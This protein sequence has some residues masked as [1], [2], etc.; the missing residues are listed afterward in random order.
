MS[1]ILERRLA[2]REPRWM[3]M[4]CV[5]P[6]GAGPAST[7]RCSAASPAGAPAPCGR[8][9]QPAAGPRRAGGGRR[10][11]PRAA[12]LRAG[13]AHHRHRPVGRDAGAGRAAA[14][15][16]ARLAQRRRRCARWTPRRPTSPMPRS[17]SRWRCSSPRWCRIRA[18]LL[19]E[20]RRVVRPGGNILF[21]NH[22]AAEKGPRGGS[23]APLAPASRA[24][25]W[26]PDFAMEALFAPRGPARSRRDP[27]VPPFGI[28]T[29][30]RVG[31]DVRSPARRV[32][33]MSRR[34]VPR[35]DAHSLD[36]AHAVR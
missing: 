24:L 28:F 33:G 18:Q 2:D 8:A 26:H 25:G 3:P 20:M 21:V 12:A 10:H 9:G 4:L 32:S 14:S 5:P 22:F 23:S 19:A 6:I 27:P 30:V 31:T 7:T 36:L 11:R 35:P 17:T 29:L 1:D 13:Q 16:T 34:A 15:P